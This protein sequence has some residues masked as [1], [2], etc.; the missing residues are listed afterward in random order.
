V[1]SDH[2][3]LGLAVPYRIRG[4]SGPLSEYLEQLECSTARSS[5]RPGYVSGG[6][7]CAPRAARRL[8]FIAAAW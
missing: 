8:P 5:A 1:S 2:E 7:R 6:C 4:F 3:A